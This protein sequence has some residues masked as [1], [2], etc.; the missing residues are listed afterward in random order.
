MWPSDHKKITFG[1]EG[2]DKKFS[3]QPPD[4]V[5]KTSTQL[6]LKEGRFYTM[7]Y[8]VRLDL[9]ESLCTLNI[10]SNRVILLWASTKLRKYATHIIKFNSN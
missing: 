3:P 4:S 6:A 10:F 9:L 7:T 2:G 5:H 8:R 1:G